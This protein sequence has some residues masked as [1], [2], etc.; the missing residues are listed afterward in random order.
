MA[1]GIPS[2]LLRMKEEGIPSFENDTV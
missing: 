2:L 1:E